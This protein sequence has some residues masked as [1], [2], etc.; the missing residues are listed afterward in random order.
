ML[1][2]LSARSPAP[3]SSQDLIQNAARAT[4]TMLGELRG[5]ADTSSFGISRIATGDALDRQERI[6]LFLKLDRVGRYWQSRNLG[7]I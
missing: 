3:E 7:S 6:F 4:R 1:N 5:L 2:M